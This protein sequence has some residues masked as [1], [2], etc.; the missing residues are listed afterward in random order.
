MNLEKNVVLKIDCLEA[1]VKNFSPNTNRHLA[2]RIRWGIG[3]RSLLD[4]KQE[5]FTGR[6]AKQAK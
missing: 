4:S 3:S 1:V 6:K 5:T 2:I